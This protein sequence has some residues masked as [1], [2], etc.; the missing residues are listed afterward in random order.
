MSS[1]RFNW[2]LVVCLPLIDMPEV[3]CVSCPVLKIFTSLLETAGVILVYETAFQRKILHMAVVNV[4]L[5]RCLRMSVISSKRENR[6]VIFVLES[7][8]VRLCMHTAGEWAGVGMLRC[9]SHVPKD[10]RTSTVLSCVAAHTKLA[11]CVWPC[12]KGSEVGAG[13]EFVCIFYL[14]CRKLRAVSVLM[15]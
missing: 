14:T 7:C 11:S 8:L 3:M 1:R 15:R 13:I 12:R 5:C 9:I 2:Q 4:Q 6:Q 10:V